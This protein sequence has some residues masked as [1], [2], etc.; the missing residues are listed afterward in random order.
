MSRSHQSWRAALSRTANSIDK[1]R[2]VGR[3]WHGHDLDATEIDGYVFSG[4]DALDGIDQGLTERNT[5]IE[6]EFG[7][8][9]GQG[10]APE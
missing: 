2:F 8:D 6:V 9:G 7:G 1:S 4:I 10:D 3:S 5:G